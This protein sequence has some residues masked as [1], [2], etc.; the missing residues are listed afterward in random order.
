MA[1]ADDERVDRRHVASV[2]RAEIKQGRY[3]PGSKLPS[4]RQLEEAHGVARNTVGAA[5]RLLEEEGL[6]DIRPNSGAYVRDP[7][8]APPQQDVRAELKELQ[9]QLHRTKRE[10]AAA[11]KRVTVLLDN[12]PAGGQGG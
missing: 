2:I 3:L 12:L 1:T 8:A 5:L 10:L 9:N 7:Q 4:Y 6:V 11:Q